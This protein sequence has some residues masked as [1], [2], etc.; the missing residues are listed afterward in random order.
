MF[1][2]F[3]QFFYPFFYLSTVL[4]KKKEPFH[5]LC[6]FFFAVVV[7]SC[8]GCVLCSLY[9]NFSDGSYRDRKLVSYIYY[10][11]EESIDLLVLFFS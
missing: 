1:V 5:F 9:C 2:Y 3:F 10:L 11:V 4:Y 8:G 6:F 7:N